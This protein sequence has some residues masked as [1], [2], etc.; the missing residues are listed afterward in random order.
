MSTFEERA[1]ARASWP[2]QRLDLGTEELSDPRGTGTIDDRIAWVAVLT[3]EQWAFGGLEVP[4]Y[5]RANM[6]GRVL[7]PRLP[8]PGQ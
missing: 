7:R 4:R 6:P 8:R 3:R 1:R 2:V 5:T